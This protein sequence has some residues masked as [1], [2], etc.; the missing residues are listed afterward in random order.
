[1][2]PVHCLA[3]RSQG[4]TVVRECNRNC[5][6]ERRIGFGHPLP[7][8]L[9]RLRSAGGLILACHMVGNEIDDDFQTGIMRTVYQVL[10]LLH[11]FSGLWLSPGLRH[12][13]L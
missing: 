8:D 11:R 6:E 12:N 2:G 3:D 5:F 4:E 1:M 10:K 9:S 13:S 7:R